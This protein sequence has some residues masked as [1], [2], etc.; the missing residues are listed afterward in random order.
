MFVLEFGVKAFFKN[1]KKEGLNSTIEPPGHKAFADEEID[2]SLG[3][4]ID[5]N[6]PRLIE[7]TFCM[8]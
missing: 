1:D 2:L 5:E 8:G 3:L 4:V 6:K 7:F